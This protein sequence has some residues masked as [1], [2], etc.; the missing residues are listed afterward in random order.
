MFAKILPIR[1]LEQTGEPAVE[2]R[3][4]ARFTTHTRGMRSRS[5]VLI[6][7]NRLEAFWKA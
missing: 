2:V 6:L 3:E 5:H 7:L 4:R 1:E